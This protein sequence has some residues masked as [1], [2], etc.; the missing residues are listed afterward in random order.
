M[1][2]TMKNYFASKGARYINNGEPT[3]WQEILWSLLSKF[4]TDCVFQLNFHTGVL[5]DTH[6]KTNMLGSVSGC[7]ESNMIM[8]Q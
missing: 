3:G 7:D 8:R 6:S 5:T 1:I 2:A 4:S